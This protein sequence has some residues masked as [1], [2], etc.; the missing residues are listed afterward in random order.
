VARLDDLNPRQKEAVAHTQGPLLV[1]AGAG[2]GKTKMLTYRIANLLH[3]HG[4][5]PSNILAVTFTNKAA[6]QMRERVAKLLGKS[7][8]DRG[9]MPFLGTFHA[10]CVRILRQESEAAGI[11]GDFVIFDAQDS[12]SAIK[13]AMRQRGVD[14]KAYNPNSIKGLI[15]SAKNEL[16]DPHTYGQL[17]SGRLQ[18]MAADIYPLY[19][20]ILRDAQ[21]L[22]F[23]DLLFVTVRLFWNDEAVLARWQ[24]QFHYILIDEYQD[25]NHAQYQL[26][27]LLG[28][29]H[30]NICVTGD[31]W[32]G[33][34]SWR[35]ANFR[36]ILEF[37]RDYPDAKTVKLEQNYRST[38]PILEAAQS[39]IVQN[40][41]RSEKNLWTEIASDHP[42]LLHQVSDEVQE[43]RRVIEHIRQSEY[44]H[45]DIAVL[46]RTNAQSRSLEDS[47]LRFGI[48]YQIVGGVR[49]YERKEIKDVL[50]YIRL[51]Y[52]LDDMVSFR[53]VVNVPPRGIGDKSL[54]AFLDWL[55][56]HGYTLSE[57]L[58]YAGD[59]PGLSGQ[60][61]K[62]LRRLRDMLEEAHRKSLAPAELIEYLIKHS[63]YMDYI[64]DG[65][66]QAPDRLENVQELIS[67]ARE[68]T[69]LAGFL[70]EVALIADIDTHRQQ[71]NG[72]TLMTLHAAKGLEFPVVF[73]T[74]ME[75]GVFPHSRSLFDAEEMEE[76]R[77]LCYVGM[78]RAMRE[79]HLLRANSRMLY[80][81]PMHNTP[82]R[83]LS[84]VDPRYIQEGTPITTKTSLPVA[85]E[86]FGEG[87]AVTH[88]TF[89]AGVVTGV[90]DQEI[91]VAFRGVG[92]KTL[93]R[94]YAPLTK[95]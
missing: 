80:G 20:Q 3:H 4:V 81:K 30:N 43:S 77:R 83:F 8:D 1:L 41:N 32:Q 75:E 19:Q 36:N 34:Y 15:S 17:A 40:E 54:E 51:V 72:V 87:D 59:I 44:D 38:E 95:Q 64:N 55:S 14:E 5:S 9:F 60:A 24:D 90:S 78:T 12:L 79:L 26:V 18:E 37:E 53:R 74:G 45:Q 28:S 47:L 93:S 57:G 70:E 27:K 33:V 67:V 92:T 29:T 65:S 76:E 35:G 16:V 84:E 23:D 91:E 48:P 22:D 86:E 69:D 68:Y 82:S 71:T 66:I 2:S 52:Q 6:S 94:G 63:G 46:Y 21:A 39:V 11:R 31:D 73:M 10:I 7:P 61:I 88:P 62:S 13:Q 50:A 42:V 89:G 56:S 49:F 85:D 25:T 58:Q